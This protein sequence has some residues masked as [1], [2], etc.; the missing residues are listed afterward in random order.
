MVDKKIDCFSV[1]GSFY[2]CNTVFE[3]MGFYFFYRPCREARSSFTD[4]EIMGGIKRRENK[5]KCAKSISNRMDTTLLK[6][7]SAIG[8]NYT[9]LMHQSKF[10]FEQISHIN[11]LSAKNNSC[12]ELSMVNSLVLFNVILKCL[13]ACATTFPSFPKFS[14]ILLYVEMISEI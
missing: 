8:R 4:N 1:G 12:K 3:A 9:E 13:N 14:K 6:C 10:I 11:V 2:H 7:G 5:T